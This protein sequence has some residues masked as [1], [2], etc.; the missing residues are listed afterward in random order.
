MNGFFTVGQRR[1][2]WWFVTP[3]G[4]PFWSIGMNHI[5]SAALRFPESD[6]VGEDEFGNSQERWL[7]A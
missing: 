5:D 6:G 1:D 2:R 7:R 4:K 3:D